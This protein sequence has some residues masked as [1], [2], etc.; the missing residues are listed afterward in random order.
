V[1][2]EQTTIY[3][4]SYVVRATR[5]AATREGLPFSDIVETALRDY[6]GFGPIEGIREK[7]DLGE[8]ETMKLAYEELHA[9]RRE[10]RRRTD[11]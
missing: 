3:L 6:L 5:A 4:D 1:P 9:M 7:A 2:R 10:R 11:S 8:G